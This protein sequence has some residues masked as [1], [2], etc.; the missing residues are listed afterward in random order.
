MLNRP[1]P[2]AGRRLPRLLLALVLGGAAAGLVYSYVGSV[3]EAARRAAPSV[4]QPAPTA[5]PIPRTKVLVA[6][7]DM[8]ARTL[9]RPELFEERELPTEAV[10]PAAVSST[11]QLVGKQLAAP[12]AAGEQLPASRLQ[13]PSVAEPDRL[14][15]LVPP[16]KRAISVAFSEVLGSGGLIVPGDHV[17]VIATFKKEARGKDQW[18]I[19]RQDVPRLAVA[20]STSPDELE[21]AA[22]ST[23]T[24]AVPPRT[25]GDARPAAPAAPAGPARSATP[26]AGDGKAV[27]PPAE[28]AS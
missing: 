22:S 21:P 16:G 25:A 17:D 5:T 27:A 26:T 19:L 13:D 8:P 1:P 11:S 9:L 18:M 7:M 14:S 15:E 20:Q 28:V 12:V 10:V 6:K 23:P 3:P 4:P 2:R 24:A